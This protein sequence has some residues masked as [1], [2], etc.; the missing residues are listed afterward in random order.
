MPWAHGGSTSARW[1]PGARLGRLS[2]RWPPQAA[3]DVLDAA[4]CRRAILLET[5]GVGQERGPRSAAQAETDRG[6]R[7]AGGLGDG[8]QAAKAGLLE[9]GDVFAV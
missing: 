4:G 8:V 1:P 2:W 6:A 9:V 5:V 7:R 3:L